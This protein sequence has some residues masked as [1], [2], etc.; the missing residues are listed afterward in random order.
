[1]QGTTRNVI[2]V[3]VSINEQAKAMEHP[4]ESGAIITDHRVIQPVEASLS[5]IIATAEF[6]AAYEQI[7][8]LYLKSALLQVYT[9]T[10]RYDNMMIVSM[11]HKEDADMVDALAVAIKLKEV[12]IVTSKRKKYAPQNPKHAKTEKR[13]VVQPEPTSGLASA[14]DASA[15]KFK[16]FFGGSKK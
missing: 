10:A 13:G 5:I 15:A 11:P 7:K 14:Y 6:A 16:N 1:M 9:R 2:A 3:N 4:V 12:V 8:A